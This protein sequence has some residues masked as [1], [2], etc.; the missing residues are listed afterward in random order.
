MT[1]DNNKKSGND[2]TESKETTAANNFTRKFLTA[3]IASLSLIFLLSL[4]FMYQS[5]ERMKKLAAQMAAEERQK[6]C[7]ICHH[8]R[9]V[10]EI[11]PSDQSIEVVKKTE[12][13]LAADKLADAIIGKGKGIEHVFIKQLVAKPAQ[14]GYKGDKAEKAIKGWAVNKAHL[15]AKAAGYIKAGK[16][17]R[18]K[19][20]GG[21]V[22]YALQ[23]KDGGGITVAKY[24]KV[25]DGR[26]KKVNNGQFE[27]TFTDFKPR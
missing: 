5:G 4:F 20:K 14:F 17:K 19:G 22:A 6:T 7:L 26:F 1:N 23:I 13:R 24:V 21:D 11:K 25:A 12:E 10:G 18:I 9:V 15:I 27:Y 2:L 16:E 8:E 3:V